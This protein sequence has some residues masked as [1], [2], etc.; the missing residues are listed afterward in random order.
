[1]MKDPYADKRMVVYVA[2][3]YLPHGKNL[4]SAEELAHKKA[5]VKQTAQIGEKIMLRGHIPLMINTTFGYWEYKSENF[6]WEVI[7]RLAFQ[8]LELADA[9]YFDEPSKGTMLELGYAKDKGLPVFTSV[10]QMPQL[11]P[12]DLLFWKDKLTIVD[13]SN[14]QE[15]LVKVRKATAEALA[16]GERKIVFDD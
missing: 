3:P 8:Y 10:D 13:H 14:V 7:M 1:M 5:Q 15:T 12:T 4:T 6:N 9:L 2:A 16:K 11:P